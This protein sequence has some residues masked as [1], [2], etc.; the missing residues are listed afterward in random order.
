MNNPIIRWFIALVAILILVPISIAQEDLQEETLLMTFMPNVQFAP[1]YVAIADGYFAEQGYD[2]TLEYLNEPDVVDLIAA[3]QANFGVVS[4][5]QV[6]L[7]GSR[8]RPILFVYNWFHEFPVGVVYNAALSLESA[9]DL[10]GLRVGIPG[11][12]GA[13]YSG[14]TAL[15]NYHGLT[16]TQIDLREIGFA[17]PD[18]F[19]VDGVDAAVVYLNNEPLQIQNLADANQCG[20][21]QDVAVFPV[22]E[23]GE[24]VSNGL[25]TRQ[26]L[27]EENPEQVAAFVTAFDQG[28]KSVIENPA[29]AYLTS[30]AFVDSL[31]LDD[32]LR[33]L[34]TEL[35]DARAAQL[36]DADWS[37]DELLAANAEM[38][39]TVISAVGAQ[40]ALQFQVLTRSIELWADESQGRANPDAWT[41]MQTL[42]LDLDLLDQPAD[43]TTLFTNDFVPMQQDEAE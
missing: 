37:L 5:E 12:F 33:E 3:G 43:L 34:L 8:G 24:L 42:L 19:C 22:S 32:D 9:A 26:Q 16:E 27:A 2:V 1:M 30:E 18:V 41:A 38:T 29:Q 21:V 15:L 7:A 14:L 31:P 17:A 20:D 36:A 23:V 25:I 4:G 28:V 11:R 35:A 10:E 6:I 39:E 13:S 40:D